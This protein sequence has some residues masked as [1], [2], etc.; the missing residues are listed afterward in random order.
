MPAIRELDVRTIPPPRRHPEIFAAFDGL[1]PEESFVLVNDHYPRP[2][3]GQFQAMRPGRFEWNV[4]EGGP[5][6]FRVEIRRRA[7]AG[8]R[9]VTEY[10][11]ADHRRLDD[12]VED[13]RRL[14]DAGSFKEASARFQE[15]VCGLKRHIDVEEQVLFPTFEQ[16]TGMKSSGPTFV[17]R[18][19][20]VEL[21]R[22]MKE[23][24]SALLAGDAARAKEELTALTE[25][26][27]NHNMKEERMLYPMTDRAAGDERARDELVK[28][29]Q[30]F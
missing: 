24:A 16:T 23:A 8:P 15:L 29:L 18:D 27:A 9:E 11:E 3:L 30:V 25:A 21:R 10:L 7:E 14:A 12:I 6:L 5:A 17:M 2:L 1:A 20:H 4:L 22:L 26:L 28:R 13:A 19:E